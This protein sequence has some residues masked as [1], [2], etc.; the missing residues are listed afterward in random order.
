MRLPL[1]PPHMLNADWLPLPA[2]R[3]V[4]GLLK[5]M[6][7]RPG[8]KLLEAEGA[9][10]EEREML[11]D[12]LHRIG[13]LPGST[14]SSLEPWSVAWAGTLLLLLLY[15]LEAQM[16]LALTSTEYPLSQRVLLE[17]CDW[18]SRFPTLLASFGPNL[19][20]LLGQYAHATIDLPIAIRHFSTAAA[21][22]AS[23][24]PHH[25]HH[26]P[27]RCLA[28]CLSAIVHLTIDDPSHGH[29]S[30]AVDILSAL[31]QEE[32]QHT[33]TRQLQHQQQG[34]A[35]PSPSATAVA[36]GDERKREQCAQL[37]A[38]A[39]LA[40]RQ[41]NLVDARSRLAQGLLVTH[42]QLSN[43]QIAAHFLLAIGGIALRTSD[44]V[45]A[46]DILRSGL[47]LFR[48]ARDTQGVVAVAAELSLLYR[49]TDDAMAESQN[50]A[51]LNRKRGELSQQVT[52]AVGT[53]GHAIL[54][55]PP[56]SGNATHYLY[57]HF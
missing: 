6:L 15:V 4:A 46:K 22:A 7:S 43:H 30:Q 20:L 54:L 12:E 2:V 9:L 3:A 31:E 10:K 56:C 27:I 26:R 39:L 28:L 14:E 36:A 25:L 16:V 35:L 52:A 13:V 17:I 37:L 40:L 49:S 29:I 53:P 5:V 45:G 44:L 18:S 38:T 33:Q 23:S 57:G 32:A 50:A 48:A 41:G 42:R 55:Q 34:A 47:T 21:K 11:R 1:G 51:Y 19:H 8:G 24:S